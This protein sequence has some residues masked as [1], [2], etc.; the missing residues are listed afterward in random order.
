MSNGPYSGNNS[1]P[2]VNRSLLLLLGL[3]AFL[4]IQ[5]QRQQWPFQQHPDQFQEQPDREITPP[6]PEPIPEPADRLK[7]TFLVVVEETK[8]RPAKRIKI[9]NNYDFWFSLHDRGLKGFRLLD[10][11][12]PDAKSFIDA[13]SQQ[14]I[15]H[16]FV[17]HVS[18]RGR[19]LKVI[20][21][22]DKITEIEEM[23][24]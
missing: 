3:I 12:S 13:A 9:L 7:D 2:P 14:S 4:V 19:V 16:P 17:M 18:P 21:F 15:Q 24:K 8:G 1:R 23:L 20:T 10:P 6:T 22:P 5:N 11:N